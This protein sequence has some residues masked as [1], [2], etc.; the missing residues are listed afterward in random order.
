MSVE[1]L[2]KEF[3]L[4]V[5][6]LLGKVNEIPNVPNPDEEKKDES[7]TPPPDNSETEDVNLD[8]GVG[9]ESGVDADLS[10]Y[11]YVNTTGTPYDYYSIF[12]QW[13]SGSNGYV[14]TTQ[15]ATHIWDKGF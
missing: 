5:D 14:Q 6:G 3:H 7:T 1:S 11:G 2:G 12:A 15:Y 10:S 9:A 4:K 13:T 8:P